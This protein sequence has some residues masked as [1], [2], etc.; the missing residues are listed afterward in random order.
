[1]RVSIFKAQYNLGK[2]FQ[3]TISPISPNPGA[4]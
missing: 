2:G 3:A 1:M 4:Q